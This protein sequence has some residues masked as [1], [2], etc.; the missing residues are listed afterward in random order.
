M[1][2]RHSVPVQNANKKS[3]ISCSPDFASEN[4]TSTILRV[5]SIKSVLDNQG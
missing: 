3:A 1:F 2:M 4:Q 5:V